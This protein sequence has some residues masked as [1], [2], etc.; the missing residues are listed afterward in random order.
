MPPQGTCAVGSQPQLGGGG[1]G[2]HSWI[3]PG[4][5]LGSPRTLVK[6]GR[7]RHQTLGTRHLWLRKTL[8][9]GGHRGMQVKSMELCRTHHL[10][11]FAVH[12]TPHVKGKGKE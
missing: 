6:E 12:V 3:T 9:L 5:R 7:G 11:V 10:C 8:R 2:V 1:G 4:V